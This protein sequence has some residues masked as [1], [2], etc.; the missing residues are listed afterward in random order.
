MPITLPPLPYANDF[1]EPVIS[2]ETLD[3][4][5]GKH[6]AGETVV[7]GNDFLASACHA[8]R[9]YVT[10]L[11]GLLQSSPALSK[12]S[13]EQLLRPSLLSQS[14][15][16]G[17]Y[18]CAAQTWNHTFY[19]KSL[20]NP[21][22]A[23]P[24]SA[25]MKALIDRS[26]GSMD[27]FKKKFSDAAAGHFGSGWAWLVQEVCALFIFTL[28]FKASGLL[29]VM[30]THDAV[31]AYTDTAVTPVLVCDVWEHAYYIDYRNNRA[32]YIEVLGKAEFLNVGGSAKDRL[33]LAVIEAA[34]KDGLIQP[35]T[36][37]TVFEGTV[38]STG[39][40]LA[41]ICR[42]KGY[43][44]HIVMPD[45]Q[46]REKYEMLERLGAT[47]E[48]VKPVSI[49]DAGHF[50]RVAQRRA[51]EMNTAAKTSGGPR[52]FFCD[53]FETSANFDTHYANTGPEIYRQTG[54]VLDAFV[55]G[56]G[57]GGTL[58]GVARYL[59]PRIKSLK[60]YLADPHGSGLY[61]KVRSGVLYS[62]TESEGSRRRHQVDSI[63]EGIGINR[64]TKNFDLVAGDGWIDDAVK[65]SDEEAVE[66]SRILMREDGVCKLDVTMAELF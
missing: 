11:N 53:Q 55:S 10:K 60:V 3:F 17:A 7:A 46:A 27:A 36:G 23:Q 49:A 32:K 58:A 48:R 19:W 6:H 64:L 28:D 1:L 43:R 4:H 24:P 59:K 5:Y 38:G 66:M 52:G 25:K 20:I 29:R 41:V 45:D 2:R 8:P 47:V 26:F 21:K 42:A 54:G 65:V 63:V 31:C 13:L 51:E 62:S 22:K 33:A 30:E 57:T 50:V 34:E 44:C 15:P 12:L 40:S 18:N 39:I 37:C 35:R 14:L 16:A 56:A 61:N 9:G